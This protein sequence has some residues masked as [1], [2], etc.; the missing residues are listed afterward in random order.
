MNK[1]TGFIELVGTD[2]QVDQNEW[3]ASANVP[4]KP[5]QQGFDISSII[6]RQGMD[7]SATGASLAI[8]G[9][10]VFFMGDPSIANGTA[11]G[12]L[13]RAQMDKIIGWFDVA[14]ADWQSWRAASAADDADI[15]F[16]ASEDDRICVPRM[17]DGDLYAALLL[18]SATSINSAAGDDEDVY[19]K[20]LYA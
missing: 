19:L 9:F 16:I 5:E 13:T 15:A 10:V 11:I 14:A 1:Q 12:A 3:S 18:T 20:V 8:T 17:A 7:G 4:I 2:E 6:L